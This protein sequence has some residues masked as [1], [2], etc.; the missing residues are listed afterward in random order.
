[1]AHKNKAAAKKPRAGSLWGAK[2]VILA[3][4]A[5]VGV[6]LFSISTRNQAAAAERAALQ[7]Q[8][9][10]LAQENEALRVALERA[11]D[12]EYLQ[13]L[14]REEYGMVSPGQRDFYDISN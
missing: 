13:Q 8:Q 14:A 11:D 2:L 10:A 4:L 9:L 5:A 1:M 6:Q 3:L 7:Q 12:P